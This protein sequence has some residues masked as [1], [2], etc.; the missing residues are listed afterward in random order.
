MLGLSWAE[1]GVILVVALLVIG[2]E[3]LPT[4]V[5]SIRKTMRA[6]AGLAADFKK[7][8]DEVVAETGIDNDITDL[9]AE[10]NKINQDVRKIIDED[11]KAWDAYDIS[12]MI[13]AR[14]KPEDNAAPAPPASD[15]DT[16]GQ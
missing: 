5:R 6:F 14:K 15:N 16:D 12:D 9:K 7:S 4:V 1:T 3:E 13:N 11:G 8:L 2:P 10:A